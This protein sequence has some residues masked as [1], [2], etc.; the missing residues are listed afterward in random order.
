MKRFIILSLRFLKFIKYGN[1]INLSEN[2]FKDIGYYIYWSLLSVVV[3]YWGYD[4]I[5]GSKEKKHF[6]GEVA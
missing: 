4:G 1:V 2:L 6:T 5:G 3:G